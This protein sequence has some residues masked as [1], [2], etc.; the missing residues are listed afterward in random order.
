M[1]PGMLGL[2][3]ALANF[4]TAANLN[5]CACVHTHHVHTREVPFL[6]WFVSNEFMVYTDDI[7]NV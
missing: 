3:T 6:E 2:L 7:N 4:S 1:V 5:W